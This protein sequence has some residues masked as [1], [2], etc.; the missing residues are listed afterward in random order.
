MIEKIICDYLSDKLG[1]VVLPEEPEEPMEEYVI[2]EKTGGGGKYI[3]NSTIAIK[4]YSPSLYLAAMLNEKVKK[5]MNKIV[6]LDEI[7]SVELNSDYNF[8]DKSRKK[9]RY[10]AVYELTHY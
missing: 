4:S 10:Q 6:E 2:V 9:Y 7:S 1:L 3:K 8:T 5:E